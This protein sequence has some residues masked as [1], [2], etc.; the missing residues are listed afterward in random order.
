MAIRVLVV[1]DVAANRL[2]L[3]KLL[4]TLNLEVIEAASGYEALQRVLEYDFALVLLDVQ[5]PEIDGF[6]VIEMLK[7]IE[8][9]R[10]LPVLLITA[11]Y[12]DDQHRLKGYLSGSVDYIE[13][14]I[15]E[16]ILLAKAQVFV[17][18]H[19]QKIQLQ[20]AAAQLRQTNEILQLQISQRVAA[21]NA[22]LESERRYYSLLANMPGTVYRCLAVEPYEF[23]FVSPAIEELCG[24]P[25]DRFEV[26]YPDLG[27]FTDVF[28]RLR[29]FAAIRRARD[30]SPDQQFSAFSVDYRIRHRN[31]A[32]RWVNNHGQETEIGSDRYIDGV[33]IDITEKKLAEEELRIAATV[34]EMR[35]GVFIL[36]RDAHILRS[37]RAF[38]QMT[39]YAPDEVIGHSP[40]L[41][42]SNRQDEAF[43]QTLW[44]SV[45]ETGYWQ[46]EIWH[47]RRN[48]DEYPTWQTITAVRDEQEEI[49]HYVA[50]FSDITER[51]NHELLIQQYAYRDFL[52]GLHNHRS[53]LDRLGHEI[54][55]AQR[56]QLRGALML[57]D[58]DHFKALNDSL[59]HDAGDELLRQVAMRLLEIMREE[60]TV[61]RM[62]GD[63]FVVLMRGAVEEQGLCL[64]KAL[65]TA[66][67][68]RRALGRPFHLGRH[69]CTV[70]P[71]IG[72]TLFPDQGDDIY[73]LLRQA[74][75]AMY[76]VKASGRDGARLFQ[77][78][79]EEG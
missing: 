14:P 44:Q 46:G 32:L 76:Q 75:I 1:D 34:F 70:T 2:A 77:M 63:E 25:L 30:S 50:V 67:R 58:L 56:R 38:S 52:T 42:Q 39:G 65:N 71:S 33:I 16:N 22:A 11:A 21:E 6:E 68:I 17:D 12:K 78:T 59:G 13:K 61:A 64:E 36:D 79:V 8:S 18:L 48:G 66:E 10:H 74:N 27:T 7:Q 45:Q 5:M 26:K 40:R 15:Q 55:I 9:T 41:L 57:I 62:G 51:K 73:E 24:Y 35:D 28:E 20:D 23:E 72:I 49:T 3:G 47:L 69:T 19:R 29:L 31:G 54:A 43:Y 4:S 60:D 53:L 37:N